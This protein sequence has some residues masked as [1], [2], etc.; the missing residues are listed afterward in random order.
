[1]LF[2]TQLFGWGK[3]GG[4]DP[5]A[6][7]D[8]HTHAGTNQ[9]TNSRAR[10]R[11]CTRTLYLYVCN[12]DN[13]RQKEKKDILNM[14]DGGRAVNGLTAARIFPLFLVHSRSVLRRRHQ[15]RSTLRGHRTRTAD[16][17]TPLQPISGSATRH[18][19]ASCAAVHGH[20]CR[21]HWRE[22]HCELSNP[23]SQ[24]AASEQEDESQPELKG[25]S[26]TVG[27]SAQRV[28]ERYSG[29]CV[30]SPCRYKPMVVNNV[31]F[32]Y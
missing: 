31:M 12:K 29:E 30:S 6:S 3:K 28:A 13:M 27:F 2:Q 25:Q 8:K 18:T 11:T 20:C 15:P 23:T 16:S 1:M 21:R 32:I 22:R 10:A 5:H 17:K 9:R 14:K 19:S 4:W 26:S 7:T 24:D